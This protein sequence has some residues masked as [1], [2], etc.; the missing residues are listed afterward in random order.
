VEKIIT[1][2]GPYLCRFGSHWRYA[3]GSRLESVW[4]CLRRLE[5]T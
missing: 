2:A 4:L 1:R 5:E 3:V